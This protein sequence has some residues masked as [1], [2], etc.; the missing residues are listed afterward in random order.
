MDAKKFWDK[1]AGQYDKLALKKYRK[2]YEETIAISK[3]YLQ[4]RDRLLDFACGT[5]ITTIELAGF[6][7]QV[8]A[9]DL[10]DEMVKIAKEKA[11]GRG[12]D[13]ITFKAATLKDDG[14]LNSSFDVITAFNI[15][16]GL[17]DVESALA[18]IR[19]LLKAGGLFLSVTDC[20][21]EKRTA[22]GILYR[23]LAKM[24][25]IPIVNAFKKD[26][27]VKMITT[28]GFAV[29]EERNLYPSPPNYYIAARKNS[30]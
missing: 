10:S 16:H 5:G 3:K 1:T 19:T 9:I 26:E 6:V 7:Q 21:G 13:N 25:F 28:Q 2:A 18:R 4:P 29:I 15:F 27:L 23:A 20:L 14:L 12:I 22:T 8:M 17:N 11:L 24:G 30:A